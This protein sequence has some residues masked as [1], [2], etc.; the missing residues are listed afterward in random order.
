MRQNRIGHR[1]SLRPVTVG[2]AAAAGGIV[3]GTPVATP[4]G[5]CAVERLAPGDSVLTFEAGPQPLGRV[6]RA[7]AAR[8]LRVPQGALD[9]RAALVLT[10][11]QGVLIE[12]DSAEALY[13]D[14]FALIP[15]LAL[16]GFRGIA[17]APRRMARA[18]ILG[19]DLPQIV[20][21]SRAVLLACPGACAGT[22]LDALRQRAARAETPLLP[23]DQARALVACLIAED[24][25]AALRRRWA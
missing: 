5:W 3:A 13:G 25:G 14:P 1:Y 9:N 6:A 4:Q 7:A 11:G 17:P 21:A 15:A 20:Y 19:F 18:V 16:D 22:G 24:V 2:G 23:L 8:L 10:A 12:S